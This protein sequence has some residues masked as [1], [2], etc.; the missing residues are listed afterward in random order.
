MEI[1]DGGRRCSAPLPSLPDL[2][3]ALEAAV[4][5]PRSRQFAALHGAS[6][7]RNQ[8]SCAFM[9]TSYPI[10]NPSAVTDSRA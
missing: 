4:L 8:R 5:A 1:R 10:R 3:P 7:T 6:G 9:C 2:G